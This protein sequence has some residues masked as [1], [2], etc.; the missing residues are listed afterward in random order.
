MRGFSSCSRD[1]YASDRELSMKNAFPGRKSFSIRMTK[2]KCT[3]EPPESCAH[4]HAITQCIYSI[5]VNTHEIVD[6]GPG[7][8]WTIKRSVYFPQYMHV[9]V[10][11][12]KTRDDEYNNEI[13]KSC[14]KR[15]VRTFNAE[16]VDGYQD[17]KMVVAFEPIPS[18][19]AWPVPDFLHILSIKVFYKNTWM[20]H[21][22]QTSSIFSRVHRCVTISSPLLVDISYVVEPEDGIL[23]G[24]YIKECSGNEHGGVDDSFRK[25][26]MEDLFF[27]DTLVAT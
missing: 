18:F 10:L 15:I 27:S 12:C 17:V 21:T 16:F 26:M 25:H 8:P 9:D 11:L 23:L 13:R 14:I 3:N 22:A 7:S 1:A 5:Q 24:E 19:R 20:G 4:D 2:R 6:T